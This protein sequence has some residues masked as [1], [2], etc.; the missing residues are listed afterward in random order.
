MASSLT[1]VP[2]AIALTYAL[3]TLWI[4]RENRKQ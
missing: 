4:L 3:G 2:L 1:L